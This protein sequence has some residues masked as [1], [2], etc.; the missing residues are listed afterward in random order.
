[1]IVVQGRSCNVERICFEIGEESC[2]VIG[3][4]IGMVSCMEGCR[5][6]DVRTAWMIGSLR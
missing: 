4:V 3:D 5:E 6:S 1:M 2:M